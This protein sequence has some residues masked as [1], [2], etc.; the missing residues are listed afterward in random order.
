M[1][2]V[3]KLIEKM[4]QELGVMA[5]YVHGGNYEPDASKARGQ[6][7]KIFKLLIDARSLLSAKLEEES[8]GD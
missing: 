1:N 4:K 6:I 7:D 5:G 2:D 3:L 8:R